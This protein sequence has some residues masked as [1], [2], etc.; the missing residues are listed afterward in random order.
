MT[1]YARIVASLQGQMSA[2]L[3]RS[4]VLDA[5]I[6]PMV[7]LMA[8]IV[9]LTMVGSSKWLLVLFAVFFGLS[10]VVYGVS[11]IHC[12][13]TQPDVLKVE[14]LSVSPVEANKLD[15]AKLHEV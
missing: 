9:G 12:L 15:T 6:W 14:T 3:S 8:G 11:Y 4:N 10:L 2:T 1:D 5:L 7:I 13:V